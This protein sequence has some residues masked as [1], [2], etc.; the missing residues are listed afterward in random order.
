MSWLRFNWDGRKERTKL[1]WNVYMGVCVCCFLHSNSIRVNSVKGKIQRQTLSFLIQV[2]QSDTVILAHRLPIAFMIRL[3]IFCFQHRWHWH[4]K[5][6]ANG[7][8]HPAIRVHRPPQTKIAHDLDVTGILLDFSFLSLN[9]VIYSFSILKNLFFGF[10]VLPRSSTSS[11]M[12][13]KI[14]ILATIDSFQP[15]QRL[16]H[17][18]FHRKFWFF[19]VTEQVAPWFSLENCCALTFVQVFLQVFIQAFTQGFIQ[20]KKKNRK[21]DLCIHIYSKYN[22]PAQ[23]FSRSYFQSK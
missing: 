8:N 14:F 17:S 22:S 10:P 19:H 1:I 2:N 6:N 5:H 4:L 13:R 16:H 15:H 23:N 12:V 9:S 20:A 7:R 11:W 18:Y 3:P 21:K